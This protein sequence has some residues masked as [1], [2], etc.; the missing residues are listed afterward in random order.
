M[1]DAYTASILNNPKYSAFL[2]G[3]QRMG[4]ML[5]NEHQ[6]ALLSTFYLA[7]RFVDDVVDGDHPLPAGFANAAE[8]VEE[9]RAFTRSLGTPRDALEHLLVQSFEH[10]H[11]LGIDIAPETDDILASMLFDAH[12]RGTLRVSPQ[13]ELDHHFYLLDIRGT[14]GGFLKTLGED[15][16]KCSYVE[17]LG[18]ACRIQYDLRDFDKDIA[19][20]YVNISAEDVTALGVHTFSM[21]D[22][23]VQQWFAVQKQRGLR[24]LAAYRENTRKVDLVW[25]GRLIAWLQYTRPAQGYFAKQKTF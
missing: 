24:H 18:R 7:M 3:H 10:A 11:H 1:D 15:P 6:R 20:G 23:G 22:H 16:A 13:E 25:K 9:K 12:R 19:A 21:S 8:Y 5:L 17:P 4:R 14:I 2:R